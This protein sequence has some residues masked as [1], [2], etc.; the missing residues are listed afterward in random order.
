M[1]TIRVHILPDDYVAA[2]RLHQRPRGV[3]AAIGIMLLALACVAFVLAAW[4]LLHGRM[5]AADA[6]VV[7]AAIYL[8]LWFFVLLP[9][10]IRR[11]YWQQRAL[12]QPHELDV[13][14]DGI[15]T[16]HPLGHGVL[17][18]T[19]VHK[20]KE[21]GDLFLVYHSDMLFNIVPK[22]GFESTQAVDDFREKLAAH[23]GPANAPVVRTSA[24]TTAA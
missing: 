11:L 14:D 16:R 4:N 13:G 7:A 19:N 20:W 23:V 18:W 10:R 17:P 21:S 24:S 12:Q 6:I 15:A 3:R 22:R 8:A 9:K 5:D 1:N 2:I